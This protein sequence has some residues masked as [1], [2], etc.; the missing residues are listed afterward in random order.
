MNQ[1]PKSSNKNKSLKETNHFPGYEQ[2]LNRIRKRSSV[3][4]LSNDEDFIS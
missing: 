2:S 1:R 4:Q 3:Y